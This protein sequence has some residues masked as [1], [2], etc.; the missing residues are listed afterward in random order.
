M[1]EEQA[2]YTNTKIFEK[3]QSRTPTRNSIRTHNGVPVPVVI[4][5]DPAYPLLLWLTKAHMV[6]FWMKKRKHS[7]LGSVEW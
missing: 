6:L 5:G 4:I 3:G 2:M 1:E 7:T